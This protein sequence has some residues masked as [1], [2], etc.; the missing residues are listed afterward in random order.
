MPG[1][2]IM[3]LNRLHAANTRLLVL[4]GVTRVQTLFRAPG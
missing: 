2:Q 3:L 4:N 1:G